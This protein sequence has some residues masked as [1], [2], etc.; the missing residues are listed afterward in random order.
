MTPK[1]TLNPEE[2]QESVD[3]RG[4][5]KI[6]IIDD[7]PNVCLTLREALGSEGFDVTTFYF[8]NNTASLRSETIAALEKNIELL[9][10]YPDLKIVL[11]GYSDAKGSEE[12]NRRLSKK[13]AESVKQFL[14]QYALKNKIEVNGKGET[15][16]VNNCG[17]DSDCD[18]TMHQK[19]RRVEIKIVKK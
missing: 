15:G 13:R 12:H 6:F 5:E 2:M 19:N 14:K 18:D 16:L 7:E 3:S 9:K 8:D 11:N 10:K 1:E 17:D 4:R